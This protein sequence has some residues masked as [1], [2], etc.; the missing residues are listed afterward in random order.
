MTTPAPAPADA[1]ASTGHALYRAIWRW[2]FYAGLLCLPILTLLAVTGGLYLF[3][4]ELNRLIHP[5][6][7]MVAP[8]TSSLPVERLAESALAAVPGTLAGYRAPASPDASAVVRIG[9]TLVYLDPA[10]GRVLG[11]EP[12]ES[13]LMQI[14]RDLHSLKLFGAGPNRL[15]EIVGGW[16]VI[17]VISGLYLWWPRGAKG[18]VVSLRGRPA[19][20]I[21]WRDLHAVTG[22]FAG[23]VILFLAVSGMPWSGV[24]GE[25]F[26]RIATASGAGYPLAM[27]DAVPRSAIPTSAALPH[28]PWTAETVPLPVSE[29]AAGRAALPIGLDRADAIIRAARMPAGYELTPP[30]GH[31]GV[32]TAAVFPDDVTRT[33]MIHIDQYSGRILADVGYGDY[34]WIGKTV[35]FG[36]GLHMGQHWGRANQL[37]MLAG[38]LALLLVSASGIVMWWKRRPAGRLAAPPPVPDRRVIRGLALVMLAGGILFPLTG[39]SMLAALVIDRLIPRSLKQRFG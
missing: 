26:N 5:G 24:W 1:E 8:A 32:Y 16:T 4:D 36:I 22:A 7:H 34:G 33:R 17:L 13:A 9:G 6:W 39:A 21:F 27:W 2:H 15:V 12:A 11:Q 18:G 10:D 38:C 25:R 28:A 30:A 31:D 37:V 19:R 14:V 20:R 3:K 29:P 35:E 23:L